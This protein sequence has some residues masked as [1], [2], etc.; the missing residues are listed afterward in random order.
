MWA[1]AEAL[2]RVKKRRLAAGRGLLLRRI[3]SSGNLLGHIFP[4]D[5]RMEWAAAT[6]DSV[7]SFPLLD[8][9][10]AH[11]FSFTS[12]LTAFLSPALHAA[13]PWLEQLLPS[14]MQNS[15]PPHKCLK[16][17]LLSAASCSSATTAMPASVSLALALPVW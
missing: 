10:L 7:L 13:H 17:W 16:M 15:F 8:P 1:G 14:Y 4:W 3:L 2:L 9:S 11:Y 12:Y 5:G 6:A